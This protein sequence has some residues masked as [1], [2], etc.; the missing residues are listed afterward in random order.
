MLFIYFILSSFIIFILSFL[1]ISFNYFFFFFSIFVF[2][3]CLS[4]LFERLILKRFVQSSFSEI[5]SNDNFLGWHCA[6]T[7]RFCLECSNDGKI[8]SGLVLACV[9]MLIKCHLCFDFQW[10]LQCPVSFRVSAVKQAVLDGAIDKKHRLR[11]DRTYSWGSGS[12]TEDNVQSTF[13]LGHWIHARATIAR[14]PI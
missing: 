2:L 13:G 8:R 9:G 3:F 1:L 10:R 11:C 12:V 5:N 14:H 7:L 6:A 4:L